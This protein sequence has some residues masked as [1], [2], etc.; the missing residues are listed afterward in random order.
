MESTTL[1][2][3]GN[4]EKN[5]TDGTPN[6]VV[7]RYA[8][9]KNLADRLDFGAL[10]ENVVVLDTE[11]TGLSFS[12]DELIHANRLA[13][14]RPHGRF[15]P[16]LPRRAAKKAESMRQKR[17]RR[18]HDTLAPIKTIGRNAVRYEGYYAVSK[19]A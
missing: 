1:R 2:M 5:V 4:L 9:L 11:T 17:R 13:N 10:D 7:E 12:H 8:S 6:D 15:G 3:C 14:Y 19:R 18:R 16:P